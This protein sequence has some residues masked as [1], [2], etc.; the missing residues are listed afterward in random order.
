[1][2]NITFLIGNGFDLTC[3]LKSRYTDTYEG[4]IKRNSSSSIIEQFKMAINKDI[5]TWADFEMQLAEYATAL[6]SE[7]DLVACIRDYEEYLSD[8]LLAEQKRFWD[9]Y[10]RLLSTTLLH[11]EMRR[12]LVQFYDGLTLND[13][14]VINTVFKSEPLLHYNF[15]TYNYTDIFENL[16]NNAIQSGHLSA[17]DS[18]H[19]LNSGV[20]HIHGALGRDITLGVDNEDQLSHITYRISNRTKRVLIKPVFLQS[21]DKARIENATQ[22]IL[23]SDIICIFGLSLGDSDLTW[24]K[25]LAQWL[26]S[27]ESHHLVY[28]KHR[29]MNKTYPTAVT[30]K[31]DDEEDVKEDLFSLLFREPL[32]KERKERIISQIHIPIGVKIF[33]IEHAMSEADKTERIKHEIE[34]V[35]IPTDV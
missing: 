21:Y 19:F 25:L 3:G 27:G 13:I 31:M 23:N 4:Y 8:Y 17:Y 14:Q 10:N 12:S 29:C 9:D 32:E 16:I 24:R 26:E 11:K 22:A 33:N 6:K 2:A 35:V 18:Y 5:Q 34:R 28:Y 20:I 1:M 7:E 30:L 15:I